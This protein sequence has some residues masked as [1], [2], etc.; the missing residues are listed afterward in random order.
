[1]KANDKILFDPGFAPIVLDSIG[2]VGYT[3]YV[4]SAV[5]DIKLKKINFPHTLRKLEKYLKENIAFYLGCLLWASYI[6]TFENK[7]LAGNKLLGEEAKEEEY[8]N[9]INFLID[10]LDKNIKRDVKYYQGKDYAIP[11][12]Y[13][14]ILK[15]YKEFLIIN[16]GF[17]DCSNTSQIKLPSTLKKPGKENLEK[18]NAVIQDSINKKDITELLNY[19]DLIF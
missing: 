9:E 5:R 19:Y 1:M 17:T 6:S 7:K 18:I 14:N 15:T 8:T 13:I 2:Q 4:F 12:E 3:Y 16:K 11:E 10:F